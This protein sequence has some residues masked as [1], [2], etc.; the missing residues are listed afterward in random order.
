M[1]KRSVMVRVQFVPTKTHVEAICSV[2]PE[3]NRDSLNGFKIQTSY[4]AT[5]EFSLATPY[6]SCN[7]IP[8]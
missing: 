6:F 4:Y 5:Q 3:G 2:Y 8:K 7:T 1:D